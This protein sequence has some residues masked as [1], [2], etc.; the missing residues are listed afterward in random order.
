MTNQKK[1]NQAILIWMDLEMTG[2]DPEQDQIIEIASLATD[3]GLNI[4]SNGPALVIHCPKTRLDQMDQWCIK[5]HGASGLTDRCINSKISMK[6]AEQLTLEWAKS[7]AP[8]GV[9]PLCGNS[10]HQDRRFLAKLMPDLEAFFHYRNIDV[11][12]LKELVRRW[13]PGLPKYKKQEA[14]LALDDII[15]S[16]GE[17]RYYKQHVFIPEEDVC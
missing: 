11:T 14:H 10:I 8:T 3:E 6:E 16:I 15:E 17:L 9:T 5:H 1:T 7:L 13:Y 2:L 4:I 12:T